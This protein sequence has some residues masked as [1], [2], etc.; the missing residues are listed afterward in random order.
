MLYCR[1]MDPI[2]ETLGPVVATK[3]V[4]HLHGE[5]L[6]GHPYKHREA[7]KLGLDPVLHSA[8]SDTPMDPGVVERCWSCGMVVAKVV[9]DRPPWRHAVDDQGGTR[10]WL[11]VD[12]LAD[13]VSRVPDDYEE[14]F[15]VRSSI[16][17]D[18]GPGYAHT[19]TCPDCGAVQESRKLIRHHLDAWR[20]AEA[21]AQSGDPEWYLSPLSLRLPRP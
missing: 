6:R 13:P 20:V 8:L 4:T 16:S 11:L 5:W 10:Q 3:P 21:A 12:R 17:K 2:D 18:H 7:L 15:P 1:A 9:L 19:Q 14:H